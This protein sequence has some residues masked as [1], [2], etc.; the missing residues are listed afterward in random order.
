MTRIGNHWGVDPFEKV[1]YEKEMA[2]KK[3]A[4]DTGELSVSP[5]SRV[6][7]LDSEPDFVPGY[8]VTPIEKGELGELSKVREELD[9]A[10]DAEMQ[11]IKVMVLVELSD[12]IGAVECYLKRHHPATSL[13]DLLKMKDASH[14]AWQNG[15]RK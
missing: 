15:K 7:N 9:E 8:H 2:E 4:V 14:R 5:F 12:M 3:M 11:G 6:F 13:D 1:T 10:L